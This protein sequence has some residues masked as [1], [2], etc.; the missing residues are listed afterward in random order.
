MKDA[1]EA[2]TLFYRKLFQ[3]DPSLR[4]LFKHD[5]DAQATKL[6]DM[7]TYIIARL[8]RM[9]DVERVITALAT[10]HAQYGARPEHYQTVGK[11]LLWTLETALGERWDD[12]TRTAWTEVYTLVATT[13]INAENGLEPVPEK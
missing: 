5:I 10:R 2:G 6:T 8:Q 4:S 7:V 11:A 9:D 12:E 1:D 13:M 3:L